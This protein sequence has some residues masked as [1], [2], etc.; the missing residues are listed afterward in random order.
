MKVHN[1]N[2]KP[3][4]IKSNFVWQS[5]IEITNM[6]LPLV[7]SPILARRLGADSIGVYSY[8]YSISYYFIIVALLGIYQYGT[9]EI[10]IVRNDKD[11][12]DKK[13]SELFLAQAFVGTV[14]LIAYILYALIFSRY[15]TLFLIQT[16]SILG[17][18]L[19]L[20]N[21][22]FSGLEEFRI[23]AVKTMIIRAI[24]V[25]LIVIF[26]KTSA[27]LPIYILIMALEPLLGALVYI[28]LAKDK[29]KLVKVSFKSSIR[30]L[31]GM[32]LLFVPILAMQ[33]YTSMDKV[34]LGQIS[35]MTQL[36]FYENSTKALIA[37]NLATA[38]STVLVPRMANLIGQ[39]DRKQF[40]TLMQ[41]SL[42]AV[43]L[44]TIAFGFG[45]AAVSQ[46]FAVVFWGEAFSACGPLIFIMSLTIPAY[47]LT[48]V[49]NNQ[50]LVPS[51]KEYIYIIATGLG[52]IINF[53][54][55][56]L[57]I[58][59][60]AAVGAAFSTL[61]T[62][63]FVLMVEGVAIRKELNILGCV[64]RNIAHIIIGIVMIISVK[65]I[66]FYVGYSIFYLFLEILIGGTLFLTLCS[67]YWA[68]SGDN[69]YL[70]I[71][72]GM[73]KH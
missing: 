36:G 39:N 50:Y 14:V 25:V 8:I 64:K 12:L 70:K 55:N 20:I 53:L 18:S 58:P 7:T 38:L 23:I 69:K 51:K 73:L 47:G 59:R 17:S 60:Y 56:Y 49:I 10:A 35:T 61:I 16:I 6:F 22:L 48:Y 43:F 34:M 66:D 26:I 40:N 42:D 65:F 13:F 46:I 21:W 44:L 54:L 24:G 4:N 32:L 68:I 1:S 45:T 11:A 30:H 72:A 71:I 67:F 33:L 28:Y 15:P 3:Q 19:F 31:K 2:N 57:M 37:K 9:R 27:D 29:V 63:Y 41:K 5:G 62:Q 52:V